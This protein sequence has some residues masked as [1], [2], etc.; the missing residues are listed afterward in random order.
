[1]ADVVFYRVRA[2]AEDGEPVCAYDNLSTEFL[3]KEMCFNLNCLAWVERVVVTE[4]ATTI[5]TNALKE[6]GKG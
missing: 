5:F 3:A 2:L 1:M 6:R 4:E